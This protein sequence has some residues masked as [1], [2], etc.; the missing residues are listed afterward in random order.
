MN[1]FGYNRLSK[2]TND[3]QGGLLIFIKDDMAFEECP[4]LTNHS[5]V[6]NLWCWV[7]V[8]SCK[9]WDIIIEG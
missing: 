6:E 3:Q 5:F 7:S 2:P 4:G 9:V 8:D 1:L